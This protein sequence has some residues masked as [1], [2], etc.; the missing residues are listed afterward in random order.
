MDSNRGHA[1]VY[2]ALAIFWL[3]VLYLILWVLT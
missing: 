2:I 3:L 1:I